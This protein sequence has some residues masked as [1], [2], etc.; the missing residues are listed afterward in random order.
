[1]DSSLDA[2]EKYPREDLTADDAVIQTDVKDSSVI[3]LLEPLQ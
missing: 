3:R 1:M 2:G